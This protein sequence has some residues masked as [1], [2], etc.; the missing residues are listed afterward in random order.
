MALPLLLIFPYKEKNRNI[1]KMIKVLIADD[2]MIVVEGLKNL[3]K[4]TDKIFVMGEASNG[5]EVLEK[6]KHN[7]VD[8]LI[9]DL[10]MPEMNGMAVIEKVKKLYPTTKILVLSSHSDSDTINKIIDLVDGYLIKN[11]IYKELVYAINELANGEIYFGEEVLKIHFKSKRKKNKSIQEARLT[12]REIDILKLIGMEHTTFQIAEKLNIASSTVETH[13]RNLIKKAG[14]KNSLGL[15]K[16]AIAKGYV[17]VE[18]S[19]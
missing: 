3:L 11:T 14:V 1:L 4:E 16:F 13:R 10:Q 18:K 15:V 9:L 12:K 19:S 17:D 5:K 7:Q 8:V 6:L 2:H